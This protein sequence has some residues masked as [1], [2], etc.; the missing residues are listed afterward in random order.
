MKALI[1]NE[2]ENKIEA[3]Q[4]AFAILS[5]SRQSALKREAR[6]FIRENPGCADNNGFWRRLS[7][8]HVTEA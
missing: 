6:A 3:S 7:A 2:A 8:R 5:R 4:A 1:S